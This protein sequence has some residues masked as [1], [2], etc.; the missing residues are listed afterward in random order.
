MALPDETC[1]FQPEA[2]EV[3]HAIPADP[4]PRPDWVGR[5]QVRQLLGEGGFACVYLALDE[6][7]QR[8]VAVKV[9]RRTLISRA[10]DAAA[11]LAEARVIATLDHPNIVPVFDVGGTEDYPCYIVSKYIEGTTLAKRIQAGRLSLPEA[12][13]LIA[14]IADALNHA[15]HK[16]IV[17][18][19]VKPGNIIL[20]A[21]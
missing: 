3:P 14:T 4:K 16:G 11:Y 21:D 7:L 15:H 20:D 17:H 9:P 19:D 10:E 13:A 18:R 1:A 12:V 6:Q 5:Y 2:T 8:L